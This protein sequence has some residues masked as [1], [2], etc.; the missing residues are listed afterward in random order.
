MYSLKQA[1][2]LAYDHLRNSLAPYG[3]YPIKGT[4]G[5]WEHETQPTKFCVCVDDFG[6]KYWSKEDKDHLCNSLGKTFKYTTDYEGENYCGLRLHWNHNLVYVDIS[7]PG[8][9][10]KVLQRLQ[11]K[12]ITW[13]LVEDEADRHGGP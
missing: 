9:V 2:I 11:Y 6:V 8:Y 12:P 7:M 5:M 3:Y 10:P 4:V 13:A 1:A